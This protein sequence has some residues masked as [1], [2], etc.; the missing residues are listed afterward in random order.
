ML[1]ATILD[2]HVFEEMVR[3]AN[4]W[5]GLVL[6]FV[7]SVL[8]AVVLPLPSEV[9]LIPVLHGTLRL[10]V[11]TPVALAFVIVISGVG[12]ALGSLAALELGHTAS[13]SGPVRRALH[14]LGVDPV[15]WSKRR[16]VTLVQEYGYAGLAVALAIPGFPD[17]VSIYAFSVLDLEPDRFAAATFLGSVGR[18]VVILLVFHSTIG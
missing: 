12:K 8:I 13:R 15:E 1:P 11:P 5:S 14:A 17:T 4:G 9:V 18:L 6:V 10:F 7:Y 2:I 16:V 3:A